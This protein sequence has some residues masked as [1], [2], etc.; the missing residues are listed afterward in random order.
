MRSNG[1]SDERILK[2]DG[3]LEKYRAG[4]LPADPAHAR[5]RQEESGRG[6]KGQEEATAPTGGFLFGF[7][8]TSSRGWAPCFEG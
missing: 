8:E 4:R 5:K 2:I 6:R 1:I 3:G 7:A